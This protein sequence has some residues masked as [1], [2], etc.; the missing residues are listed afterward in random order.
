MKKVFLAAIA[1]LALV[2]LVSPLAAPAAKPKPKPAPAKPLQ[3]GLSEQNAEAFLNPLMAPLN[4]Q[5][6]RLIIPYDA[7]F[8][9]GG[10]AKLDSWLGAV[11]FVGIKPLVSFNPRGSDDC[12]S[13]HRTGIGTCHLPSSREYKHAFLAFRAR[14]PWVTDY[15]PWNE[16]NHYSQPTYKKPKAAAAYY[17]V[18]RKNCKG[19]TIVSIDLLD[20]KNVKPSIKYLKT[21]MKYAKGEKVFGLHNYADTNRGVNTRTKAVIKALPKKARLWLTETGGIV[22]LDGVYPYS[23]TR[24]A[25]SLRT[26]LRIADTFPQIDRLYIYNWTGAQRGLRFDSGLVGPDGSPRLGYYVLRNRALKKP[27]VNGIRPTTRGATACRK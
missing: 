26:M 20:D 15:S 23:L 10:R 25:R 9:T 19:C 14:Y 12:G 27:C 7:I 4:I 22:N 3:L 8:T 11:Q 18:V 16:V 24:A 2:A 21:F 13:L 17:E 1:C 5:N 6:A